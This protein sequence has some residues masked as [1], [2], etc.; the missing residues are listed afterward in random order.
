MVAGGGVRVAGGGV[1]VA[2]GGVRVA[3]KIRSIQIPKCYFST[4]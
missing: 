4:V 1:R 3:G 2:G